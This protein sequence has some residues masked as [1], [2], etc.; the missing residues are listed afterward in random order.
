MFRKYYRKNNSKI[1]FKKS[2]RVLKDI[3]YAGRNSRA[4][5]SF[6]NLTTAQTNKENRVNQL[7][8]FFS[9]G[10]KYKTLFKIRN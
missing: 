10:I 7:L 8:Y 4:L 9:N 2:N 6:A 5:A 1:N 3:C